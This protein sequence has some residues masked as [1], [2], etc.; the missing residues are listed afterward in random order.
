MKKLTYPQIDNMDLWKRIVS[1]KGKIARNKLLPFQEKIEK[2]YIFY[3]QNFNSLDNISPLPQTEWASVKEELI[4]CYGNNTEFKKVRRQI[5]EQLSTLGQMKCPY[6][7]LSRPNTLEHY[8][9]KY[10]YPEFSVYVPNLVPCCSEC[11]SDKS[12]SVFDLHNNRK[13]IHFYHDL[14]PEDQFLFVRFSFLG[15]DSIPQVNIML[16][17]NEDNYYSEL[18]KRHFEDLSLISK[19]RNTILERLAPLIEEIRM[20]QQSGISTEIIIKSLNS[21]WKSLSMYYGN[22]Y[23]ETCIFEGILNS[24]DFLSRI[25]PGR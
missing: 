6:C 9:D 20:Y 12:T 7:M 11:N 19:Y 13:Y 10:N 5:F 17:F 16:K 18:I 8:F 4:S 23:W 2:R 3:A 15:L 14:I 24:P 1:R 22:N 25:L 21:R